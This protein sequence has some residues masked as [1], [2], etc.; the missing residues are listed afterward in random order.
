M[1]RDNLFNFFRRMFK[2]L[3]IVLFFITQGQ[4]KIRKPTG[5]YGRHVLRRTSSTSW[6]DEPRRTNTDRILS[7]RSVKS[8]FIGNEQDYNYIRAVCE[9]EGVEFTDT[10]FR[11]AWDCYGGAKLVKK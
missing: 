2:Y 7:L 1:N 10:Y 8:Y 11:S 5:V 4:K 3:A 6:Q 9:R